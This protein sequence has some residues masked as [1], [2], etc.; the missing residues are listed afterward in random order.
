MHFLIDSTLLRLEKDLHQKRRSYLSRE[1]IV[2]VQ[3]NYK[4]NVIWD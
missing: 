1:L 3:A 4:M 2:K